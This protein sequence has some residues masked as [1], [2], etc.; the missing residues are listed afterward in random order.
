MTGMGGTAPYSII[1]SERSGSPIG[2]IGGLQIT[3]LTAGVVDVT[4]RDDN[5]CPDVSDSTTIG[6]PPAVSGTLSD[7][8]CPGAPI[9]EV[10]SPSGGNA[11]FNYNLEI[12]GDDLSPA[13]LVATG[14]TAPPIS[15]STSH[16]V[17][18]LEGVCRGDLG[19]IT[20]TDPGAFVFDTTI[21]HETCDGDADG[22]V[23]LDI[24][25]GGTAPYTLVNDDG[26]P[27]TPGGPPWS[28]TGISPNTYTIEIEDDR[29]CRTTTDVTINAA[30][31]VTASHTEVSSVTYVGLGALMWEW[32]EKW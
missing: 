11:P 12:D 1:S 22:M 2:T 20:P 10:T 18:L 5:G 31:A 3:D 28:W 7:V 4:I 25:S 23:T 30:S 29:G 15:F 8:S 9:I 16:S 13:S 14:S 26:L 32:G 21:T 27:G 17:F 6:A 24:T 19:S